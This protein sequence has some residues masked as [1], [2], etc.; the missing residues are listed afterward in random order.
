MIAPG[1]TA[2]GELCISTSKATRSILVGESAL[3]QGLLLGRY[4]RC[5]NAEF[6]LLDEE[7]ISRIHAML[8]KRNHRIYANDTASTNEIFQNGQPRTIIELT[9]G[10]RVEL[11]GGAIVLEWKPLN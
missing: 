5:D 8:L 9:Y 6:D 7:S 4:V 2:L 1:E 10:S 3:S 11:H